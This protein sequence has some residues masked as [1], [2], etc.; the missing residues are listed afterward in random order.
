[1]IEPLAVGWHAVKVSPIQPGE[2]ALV[3]GGGP[4]GLSVIQALRAQG[5]GLVIVSEMAE[6]RKQFARQFGADHILD[7]TKDDVP[8]R[9]KELSPDG[10]GPTCVF[11]A[12]GV[13]AGL[14]SAIDALRVRGTLVNIAIWEKGC[15]LM[16][17]KILLKEKKYMG[18]VTYSRGD[19]QDVLNAISHGT[20]APA[21]MITKKIKLKDIIEDVSLTNSTHLLSNH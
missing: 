12:A 10:E 6:K 4:I 11:D 5:V 16:P 21:P 15:Q 19:F 14:D 17:T 20:I 9:C 1:M 13:Q 8:A 2:T 3:L 18:V 7:P